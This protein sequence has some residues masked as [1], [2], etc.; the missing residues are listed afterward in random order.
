[1]KLKII[2]DNYTAAP[3]LKEDWGFSCLIN[4][5]ILFDSGWHEEIFWYN[6]RNMEI[7]LQKIKLFILSHEHY[8][9]IGSLYSLL[10]ENP[11]IQVI[12]CQ[13]TSSQTQKQILAL[14]DNVRLTGSDFSPKTNLVW[15]SA[16]EKIFVTPQFSFNYKG[17][18]MV[19]QSLVIHNATGINLLCGCS[20]PGIINI[21][22]KVREFFPTE[23]FHLAAGGFHLKD[24]SRPQIMDIVHQFKNYKIQKVAPTHCTG[25]DA[26]NAFRQEYQKDFLPL[27]AGRIIQF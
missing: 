6:L 1:M 18:P 15:Q 22:Q 23:N 20:H 8:D 24:T 19:E 14:T 25:K 10:K 9:H 7:D 21:I 5:E 27:G 26:E 12:I 13:N 11:G 3:H 17:T 16:A 2:V 4:D